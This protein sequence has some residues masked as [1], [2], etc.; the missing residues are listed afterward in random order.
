METADGFSVNSEELQ[1]LLFADDGAFI[2][3][4]PEK[5]QNFLNDLDNKAKKIGLSIYDGKTKWMK[6][7]FCP[8]LSMK[9]SSENIELAEQHSHLDRV[10]K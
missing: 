6:N 4:D 3:D 9:L 1:M 8:Q 2:A 7:A 10:C 5:L